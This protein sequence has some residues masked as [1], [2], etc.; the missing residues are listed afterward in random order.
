MGRAPARAAGTGSP[1]GRGVWVSWAGAMTPDSLP[2]GPAE[3]KGCA[4]LL[5]HSSCSPRVLDQV[6]QGLKHVTGV[7]QHTANWKIGSARG[8]LLVGSGRAPPTPL[9]PAFTAR[10]RGGRL[11]LLLLLRSGGGLGS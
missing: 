4:A 8:Q 6:G 5:V 7:R 9:A 2:A 10:P 11:L 3:G 1:G